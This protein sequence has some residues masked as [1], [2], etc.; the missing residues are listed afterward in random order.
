[1]S[2]KLNC[3]FRSKNK[4]V[5]PITTTALKKLTEQGRITA[6]TLIRRG[7]DGEW[8][9][10]GRVG[11]LVS[12]IDDG[13]LTKFVENLPK[14]NLSLGSSHR[15]SKRI[16]SWLVVIMGIL[17]GTIFLG[18]AIH[19]SASHNIIDLNN[20]G[21]NIRLTQQTHKRVIREYL[22]EN[23]NSGEWEEVRWWEP[24][25]LQGSK[26]YS[27]PVRESTSYRLYEG[28]WKEENE[29]G[30]SV[31]LKYRTQGLGGKILFDRTF[32][33]DES[34]FIFNVKNSIDFRLPGE[35]IDH[36]ADRMIG[37]LEHEQV[38]KERNENLIQG[39]H[40]LAKPKNVEKRKPPPVLD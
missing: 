40:E 32:L 10:A 31:R 33:I 27:P 34:D 20:I 5:G 23:L 8:V 17:L 37:K 22:A 9:E 30:L 21:A 3:Y 28:F 6:K 26:I 35:S 25:S 36:Y 15:N 11:G 38:R 14:E 2:E 24:N 29:R 1:M 13:H 39:L 4:V 12:Y 16:P 19:F 18:V 7:E